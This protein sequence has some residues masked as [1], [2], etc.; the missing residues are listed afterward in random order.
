M[1]SV[2]KIKAQFTNGCKIKKE[3]NIPVIAVNENHKEEHV[4][5][6]IKN[7]YVVF[8][9]IGIGML[10]DPEFANDVINSEPLISAQDIRIIYGLLTIRFVRQEETNKIMDIEFLPK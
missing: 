8:A 9:D 6:L 1:H 7:K 3:V 10:D 2:F 4:R 5:L